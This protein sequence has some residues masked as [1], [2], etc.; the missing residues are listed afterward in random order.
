MTQ[1]KAPLILS[2]TY[3]I[4]CVHNREKREVV[5]L[6]FDPKKSKPQMCSCCENI[7]LTRDDTPRFCDICCK[8]PTFALQGP[9]KD[10]TGVI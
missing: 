7:F 4:Y 10:P 9:L 3:K 8:R 6:V 2:G 5:E 1:V